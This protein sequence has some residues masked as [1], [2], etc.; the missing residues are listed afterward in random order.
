MH[1]S[2]IACLRKRQ[3]TLSMSERIAALERR[4]VTDAA[5]A[6][7]E[8]GNARRTDVPPARR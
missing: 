7:V 1:A 2:S 6:A 5:E 4:V 3:A 8:L